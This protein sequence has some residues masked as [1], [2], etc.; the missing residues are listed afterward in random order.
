MT[1][2][3]MPDHFELISF[4]VA[5]QRAGTMMEAQL[6]ANVLNKQ[7]MSPLPMPT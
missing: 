4:S 2:G 6:G 7:E 5:Q 1:P 3:V